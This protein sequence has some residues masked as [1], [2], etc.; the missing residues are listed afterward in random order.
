ML[1]NATKYLTPE[2]HLHVQLH[3]KTNSITW[4][5]SF[6]LWELWTVFKMHS[7]R[8][9]ERRRCPSDRFQAAFDSW[10]ISQWKQMCS[11][12]KIIEE[13]LILHS[14]WHAALSSFSHQMK[15]D[16]CDQSH[17]FATS[18]FFWWHPTHQLCVIS[19]I[20]AVRWV[21]LCCCGCD[22]S[23]P[24][25]VGEMPHMF[26]FFL[27]ILSLHVSLSQLCLPLATASLCQPPWEKEVCVCVGRNLCG[28]ILDG[29]HKIPEFLRNLRKKMNCPLVSRLCVAYLFTQLFLGCGFFFPQWIL[30]LLAVG[31]T[32]WHTEVINK[33]ELTQSQTE[34]T[35]ERHMEGLSG[36]WIIS[37]AQSK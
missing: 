11:Y 19:A 23:A 21:T 35:L 4:F 28:I 9:A 2:P 30:D 25:P 27:S 29:L 36:P 26:S 10:I 5:P 12:L 33:V 37:A 7:C 1:K 8:H 32:Q 31:F 34:N 20:R 24:L 22:S 18:S 6:I 16:L 17:L 3:S 15:E 14:Q 13:V